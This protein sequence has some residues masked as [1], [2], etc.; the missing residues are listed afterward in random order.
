MKHDLTTGTWQDDTG[1]PI[2]IILVSTT[3]TVVSGESEKSC[4]VPFRNVSRRRVIIPIDVVLVARKGGEYK[5]LGTGERSHRRGGGRS[6][7]RRSG[8][9]EERRRRRKIF[10]RIHNNFFFLLTLARRK[11]QR[12]VD[13]NG[14]NDRADGADGR[15][16]CVDGDRRKRSGGEGDDG[17]D[18]SCLSDWLG[19]DFEGE[20]HEQSQQRRGRW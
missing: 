12:Q 17:D 16:L 11:S 5:N 18:D 2:S 7:R 4:V 20:F 8:G 14:K 3:V 9:R 1:C 6:D 15:A 13:N 19:F 10:N